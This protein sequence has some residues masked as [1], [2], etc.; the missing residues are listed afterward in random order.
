M[1]F[2]V[3]I[4]GAEL[5]KMVWVIVTVKLVE[6]V[7]SSFISM[8]YMLLVVT[9]IGNIVPDAGVTCLDQMVTATLSVAVT[10]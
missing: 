4:A 5:S 3:V 8:Q 1:L 7:V 2:D 9:P 6:P 10:H